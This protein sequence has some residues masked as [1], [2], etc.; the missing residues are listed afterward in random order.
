MYVSPFLTVNS[1]DTGDRALVTLFGEVDL[2]SA[3]FLREML[4]QYV[5]AGVR[6][7]D[8]DVTAV[9]FCD[10]SGINIFLEAGGHAAAAGGVLRLHHPNPALQRL[11]VRTGAG[12]YLLGVPFL[13]A[14]GALRGTYARPPLS[15]PAPSADTHGSSGAID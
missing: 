2:S 3:V 9:T 14:S 5:C 12:P 8:I 11:L 6:R 1:E 10:V 13:L 7:I 15:G 4:T